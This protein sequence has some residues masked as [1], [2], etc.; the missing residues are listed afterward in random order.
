MPDVRALQEYLAQTSDLGRARALLAWDERTHMPPAGAE[1]RSE[2]LATLARL[3]HERLT[4]DE[5]GRMLDD[6]EPQ[7]ADMPF[8]SFEASLVRVAR[9]D[10]EKA[11][12]VPVDLRAELSRVASVSE[13][14]WVEA[15]ERSDFAAFLPHL[16]RVVELR[17]QYVECFAPYDHP[18]DPLLDDFEPGMTTA[19]L[20]PVLESLRTGVEPLVTAIRESDANVDASCL[21]GSFAQAQQAEL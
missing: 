19:E 12:R 11:S 2:Q 6:L 14:A 20:R 7:V 1:A 8:D 9:R 17:R 5:L 10:W 21:H 3:R 4:S 18:Y 15:R 16:E 13:H